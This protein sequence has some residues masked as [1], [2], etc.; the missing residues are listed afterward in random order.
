MREFK[1]T[2]C[3]VQT[4]ETAGL[5]LEYLDRRLDPSVAIGVERHLASCED[6]QRVVSAQRSVWDALDTWQPSQISS[7]FNER[8]FARLEAEK[9]K[10]GWFAS[11]RNFVESNFSM[12]AAI[13]AAVACTLLVGVFAFRA[14]NLTGGVETQAEATVDVEQAETTLADIDALQQLGVSQAVDEVSSKQAL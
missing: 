12:R 14:S 8:L 7:D 13:P 10:P 1:Q 6:C 5:L 3:P 9:A 11:I 2:G 4:Q